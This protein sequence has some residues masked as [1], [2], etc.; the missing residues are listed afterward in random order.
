[1][2]NRAQNNGIPLGSC[3][4]L[5]VIAMAVLCASSMAQTA[6]EAA[7]EDFFNALSR[8]DSQKI[9]AF[10]QNSGNLRQSNEQGNTP[11][12]MAVKRGNSF[13][14]E[15]LL[16]H[17]A[18]M[19]ARNRQGQTALEV[20]ADE[21]RRSEYLS[22]RAIAHAFVRYHLHPK[23]T[24]ADR[25][26]ELR[27]RVALRARD[28][29]MSRQAVADG[30]DPNAT[31]DSFDNTVLHSSMWSE[32]VPFVVEIGGDVNRVNKR[33]ESPLRSALKRGDVQMTRALLVNGATL[34]IDA[35]LSDLL[36]VIRGRSNVASTLV[37]LLLDAGAPVRQVEWRSAMGTRD[38]KLVRR[39]WRHS[40]FDPES[41][42]GEELIA[43]AVKLGGDGVMTVLRSN[44]EL[45]DYI[46]NRD[47]ASQRGR[48]RGIRRFWGR[49]APH[50]IV[51]AA[52]IFGFAFLSRMP[53]RLLLNRAYTPFVAVS[54]ALMTHLFIFTPVVE[55]GLTEFRFF[56]ERVPSLRY[57]AYLFF[58]G[59]ALLVG[60]MVA[61]EARRAAAE[62]KRQPAATAGA[63][64][65]FVAVFGI[66]VAHNAA[67]ITWPTA[68]Y[69]RVT[70]VDAYVAKQDQERQEARDKR[71]AAVREANARKAS[72]PYAPLFRAIQQDDPVAVVAAL[73][74]GLPVDT[75]NDRG[76]TA[77]FAAA[78]DGRADVIPVLLDAGADP[79]ALH[80]GGRR[81]V[82][83]L[84]ANGIGP[85]D[86][87]LMTQLIDAGANLN[88]RTDAGGTPLCSAHQKKH[89]ARSQAYFLL[90]L[91]HGANLKYSD[92]CATEL[93]AVNAK[94]FL[95]HLKL[96]AN[97]IDERR[98][99]A[100]LNDE[101]G[102][103]EA[104]PLWRAAYENRIDDVR[105]LL[106]LGADIEFRDTK[107]G[108]TPL[109]IVVE[110]SQ[111]SPE[112]ARALVELLTAGG[113][114]TAAI[115]WDGSKLSD[116]E[117]QCRLQTLN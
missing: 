80:G 91:D 113:A 48:D 11:L 73:E 23:P 68:A 85:R 38:K 105:L 60:W 41:P 92:R 86:P 44:P 111:Y 109:Q 50:I 9:L 55:T 66:L 12:H 29:E 116:C 49:L 46:Q 71:A 72:A 64:S 18:D 112:R 78:S 101:L 82:H 43:E 89:T 110:R 57:F 47:A 97:D 65:L 28:K 32:M 58:D 75:R 61:A 63:V 87:Q 81:P 69:Q 13:A 5:F 107:R 40:P 79:N 3:R 76:A 100:E 98:P 117:Q 8:A 56:S 10:V 52:L 88:A 95:P 17:G 51:I 35:E 42:E 94:F 14:V 21:T 7:T 74:S 20:L 104:A 99:F 106:D 25:R 2:M 93:Y 24:G 115:A 19:S 33:R 108:M 84:S 39:L 90:L 67:T 30:A 59:A 37:D 102:L 31:I 54:T 6:G 70:G 27:F 1:M 45:A 114:D 36:L 83:A 15:L 34:S 53:A 96:T 16:A 22:K 103:Y 26:A 4:L 62:W 77:L